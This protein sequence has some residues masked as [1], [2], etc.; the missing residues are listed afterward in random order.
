MDQKKLMKAIKLKKNHKDSRGY[1]SDIFY[2]KNIKHVTFIKSKK[3]VVRGNNYFKKNY[4]YIYNLNSSFEYWFKKANLKDKPKM[5][6]IK[7]GELLCTPPLE[8]HAL[9]FLKD[10][11]LIEFSTLS[12]RQ[13]NK[14]KDS[15]KFTIK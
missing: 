7:K 4:Q 6:I 12:L 3:G 5:K 9:K 14:L 15:I 11:M 2:K 8:V 10:N 13:K 1:I